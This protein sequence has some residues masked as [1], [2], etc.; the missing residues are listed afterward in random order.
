MLSTPLEMCTHKINHQRIDGIQRRE[1]RHAVD[2]SLS[3]IAT[4]ENHPSQAA[5]KSKQQPQATDA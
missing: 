4:A 3:E 5:Q 1:S 2:S